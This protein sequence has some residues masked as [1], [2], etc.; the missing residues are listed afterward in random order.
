VSRHSTLGLPRCCLTLPITTEHTEDTEAIHEDSFSVISVISVVDVET[1][2][3][4][5]PDNP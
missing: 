2:T 1:E 3:L 5:L 4:P